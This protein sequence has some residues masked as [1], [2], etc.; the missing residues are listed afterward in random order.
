[1]HIRQGDMVVLG[2]AVT[3]AKHVD[4]RALGKEAKGSVARV[5]KV[6]VKNER[7]IIEGVCYRY[8]HAH[9][10]YRS[11]RAERIAREVPIHASNVMLYCAK[12]QR[13]VRVKFQAVERTDPRGKHRRDV[14]R[15]CRLC[16]ES[17]GSGG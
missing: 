17:V 4:G 7:L 3:G 2:K 15:V 5:L 14:A 1:M 16:G 6:D 12:C 10:S 8:K 9:R 13:G 11:P